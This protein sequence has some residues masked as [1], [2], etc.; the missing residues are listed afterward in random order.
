MD[1]PSFTGSDDRD[2]LTTEDREERCPDCHA[3]VDDGC[4]KTC[5]CARCRT[6]EYEAQPNGDAA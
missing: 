6:A 3:H 5:G 4:E 1:A 2:T